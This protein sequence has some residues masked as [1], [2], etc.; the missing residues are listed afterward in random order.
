MTEATWIDSIIYIAGFMLAL[1]LAYMG[2]KVNQ[3]LAIRIQRPIIQLKSGAE[4]PSYL[5]KLYADATN[6]LTP[7]GF[8]LHHCQVSQ[9]TVAHAAI[10]RWSLVLAHPD[11]KVFAEISP[12]S[13][14]MDMPGYEVN[15]WSIAPDGNSLLT[16]NGRAYTVFSEI[17]GV[18]IHDPLA[19]SLHQ[20]Y[21]HHLEERR[22][23][24]SSTNYQLPDAAAYI[25]LQQRLLDGYI[26]NLSQERGIVAKGNNQ[27]RLSLLKCLKIMLAH[28]NG[29][30]Q[31]RKLAK[32]RFKLKL[33]NKLTG[34]GSKAMPSFQYP[35]ESDVLSYRRL[36]A[37]RERQLSGLP[38]KILLLAATLVITY[39][40]LQLPF[41]TYS[42]L[43][44]LA[45][46][47]LHELGHFLAMLVY[48]Y[49]DSDSLC[50]QLMGTASAAGKEN[51][52]CW[53]QIIIILMGPLPGIVAGFLLLA[54]HQRDPIP[55]LYE[56]AI[57]FLLL[58]YL[59][60]LPFSS[61]DGGRLLR[62]AVLRHWPTGKLLI[63][64]LVAS[65]F[66]AGA[67]YGS[68][69]LFWILS[70]LVFISIPLTIR[71]SSVLRELYRQM[72]GKGKNSA[73]AGSFYSLDLNNKLARVF[74]ALKN[75][76]Y[77][78]YDFST[79]F[80]LVKSLNGVIT[81]TPR[82][83]TITSAGFLIVYL[84]ALAFVPQYAMQFSQN[85]EHYSRSNSVFTGQVAK[86][87]LDTKIANAATPEEQFS[88]LLRASSLALQKKETEKA[89]KYLEHAES[90]YGN[91]NTDEALAR[92]FTGY[93]SYHQHKNEFATA[94]NY[95]QK[96]IA[97]YEKDSPTYHYELAAG[98]QQLSAIRMKQ[99]NS[100]QSEIDLQKG[101][102]YA[103]QIN[104]PEKWGLITRITGQLLDWYYLE[105]RQQD[106]NQ[107]MDTLKNKFANRDDAIKNYISLFI[108]E[109]LGWLHA[110]A[111]D[112][113]AAMEKFDKALSLA[114]QITSSEGAR[115]IA[116]QLETRLVL[117]K[118]AIYYKE[119]YTDFSK[120][121]FSNAE[122]LARENSYP[123]LQDYIEKHSPKMSTLELKN[124]HHREIS[125]WKLI[126]DAYREARG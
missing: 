10:P 16:I 118:A 116:H 74:L 73:N 87:D 70:M 40:A 53:K 100:G 79:K 17:P 44:L 121:Q 43:I 64:G 114:E 126:T 105:G 80:N 102:S 28:A 23:W 108:F 51:V 50:V 26:E 59:Q 42:I 2:N 72:K 76:K 110:T 54:L 66:A 29:E 33:K 68:E 58:N 30:K 113:K 98:Y 55:W 88:L 99:G 19:Q 119:G 25:K 24:S 63:L 109:E 84:G 62:L 52:A 92:L 125:R 111:N 124:R 22:E 21:D 41:S 94:A 48:R 18:T 11:S 115:D 56:A 78:K 61:L 90:T 81:S 85:S 112:E 65:A 71:E 31:A 5:K 69:P 49:R 6:Q 4:I 27:F 60:L 104:Q 82:T 8:K 106:A 36:S 45:G 46:I 120:M 75:P 13:T 107:L 7:L 117:S 123:T 86:N 15:F 97:L 3:L 47:L 122:T 89:G 14:A 34:T 77:R 95:Q 37:V 1:I 9:D 103:I 38:A 32:T 57:I 96:A 91:I 39:V 93:S 101:L 12:A 35:V 20:Q 67:Y 83:S